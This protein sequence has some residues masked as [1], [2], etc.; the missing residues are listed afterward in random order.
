MAFLNSFLCKNKRTHNIMDRN[1]LV[2]SFDLKKSEDFLRNHCDIECLSEFFENLLQ[3]WK[4][5]WRNFD[6]CR[7]DVK[8]KIDIAFD[9]LSMRDYFNDIYLDYLYVALECIILNR[10]HDKIYSLIS[11][12]HD[13]IDKLFYEKCKRLSDKDITAEQLGAPPDYAIPLFAAVVEFSNLDVRKSPIEKV[14]CLCTTYDLIFAELKSGIIEII[15]KSDMENQIPVI[16]NKDIV[17]ILMAVII[18]SKIIHLHSNMYYIEHFL[19]KLQNSQDVQN[20][21]SN[22]KVAIEKISTL[23]DE[24]LKP[25]DGKICKEMDSLKMM[26]LMT[27]E[28]KYKKDEK[29]SLVEN[30]VHRIYNLILT[31]T[32]CKLNY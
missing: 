14:N 18:K 20:T 19:W 21:I 3:K 9:E 31:S 15:S 11:F 10:L 6:D 24:D 26:Q 28:E 25:C 13:E 12:D 16:E 8:E 17:P 5:K 1:D 27:T 4:Q 32:T 22:F 7:E 29:K 2:N 23:S 30:H